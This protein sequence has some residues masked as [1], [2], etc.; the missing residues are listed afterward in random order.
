[1]R[2]L[3]LNTKIAKNLPGEEIPTIEIERRKAKMECSHI[4]GEIYLSGYHPA[5]DELFL[6]SN[7]FTH[8]LNCAFGSRSFKPVLF[9]GIDY[10]LLD[11]RDEPG[12]DLIYSI[13]QTIDFIEKAVK[14]NGKVLIHCAEVS[15]ALFN[16]IF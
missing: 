3:K 14:Q 9:E 1:M 12:F 2:G 7:N 6:T 4:S 8:V 10:L 13:Y 11:L 15:T 16:H 5:T